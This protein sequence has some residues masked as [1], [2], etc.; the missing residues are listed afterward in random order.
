LINDTD[1]EVMRQLR[2]ELDLLQK[3]EEECQHKMYEM[4]KEY[5]PN[6]LAN[7]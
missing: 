4:C 7:L 5:Y 2:E 6:Q 1:V 3:H